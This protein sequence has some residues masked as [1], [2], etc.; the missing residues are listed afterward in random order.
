M[1]YLYCHVLLLVTIDGVGLTTGFIGSH[2]YI[3]TV[4]ALYNSQFTVTGAESSH[5][6]FTGCLSTNT[7]GSVHFHNAVVTL[8][9]V[10]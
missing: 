2:S 4:Y 3:I 10:I 6:V 5:Y 1:P 9:P 7:V 8:P